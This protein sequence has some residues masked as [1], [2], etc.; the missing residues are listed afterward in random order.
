M[1]GLIECG[2]LVGAFVGFAVVVLVGDLL[3]V[4]AAESDDVGLTDD[5]IFGF[6][7]KVV[8]GDR[9]VAVGLSECGLLVGPVVREVVGIAVG[10]DVGFRED[11]P[12]GF[13]G[14]VAS[15]PDGPVAYTKLSY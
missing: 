9:V 6:A 4:G 8:D 2:R 10:A 7:G 3:S 1:V 5:D 12:F 13:A 14:K 11:D 15:A